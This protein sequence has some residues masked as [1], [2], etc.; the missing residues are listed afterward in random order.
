M[1]IASGE[2]KSEH[3]TSKQFLC[4]L[5]KKQNR[6]KMFTIMEGDHDLPF[7]FFFITTI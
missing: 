2:L 7:V 5:C 4:N 1:L 3:N 6:K